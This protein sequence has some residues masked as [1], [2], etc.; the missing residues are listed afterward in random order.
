MTRQSLDV[1]AITA[2]LWF[3]AKFLRYAFPPLF[4][5][6]QGIFTVTSATLGL[7]FTGFML[8]YAAMQFPSGV[9]RD[10]AGPVG[11][12]TGGAAIAGGGALS[13]GLDLGFVGVVIAMVVIGLGTGFHKT[14]SVTLLAGVYPSRTGRVLG[15]HDTVGATAGLAAPLVAVGF[16]DVVGWRVAFVAAGIAALFLAAIARIRIPPRVPAAAVSESASSSNHSIVAYGSL[17]TDRQ[18]LLFLVLTVG[19]SFAYNGAVAFLPLYLVAVGDLSVGLA[20]TLFSA[21]FAVAAVQ[22]LTGELS[23]RIGRLAIILVSLGFCVV[24]FGGLLF[25]SHPLALGLAVVGLGLG[26]HGYRPPRDAYLA[27][28]LPDRVAGGGIGMIRSVI[29]GAG[30]VAPG[31]VGVTADLASFRVAFGFLWAAVLVATLATIALT[32]LDSSS[33]GDK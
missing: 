32:I 1:L 23:D 5:P 2:G 12:L 21:L 6:L 29:M 18:F 16:L 8:A 4:E 22:L 20:G 13:L 3:L 10:R 25:L 11:V 15:V 14:V 26:A 30:A 7:A 28:L 9:L 19:V 31:V 27:A 17:G 24:G 33:G